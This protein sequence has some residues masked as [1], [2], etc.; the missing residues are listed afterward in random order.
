M[1]QQLLNTTNAGRLAPLRRLGPG[2]PPWPSGQHLGFSGDGRWLSSTEQRGQDRMRWWKL[3]ERT[4]SPAVSLSLKNGAAAVVLAGVDR[5]LSATLGGVLQEWSAVDGALRREHDLGAGVSGL[6]LAADGRTLLITGGNG[7]AWLWDVERWQRVGELEKRTRL[8]YGCALSPD[9]RLAAAGAG[10]QGQSAPGSVLI[11][12]VATGTLTKE[13]PLEAYWV[14]SVAFHPSEPLLVAGTPSHGLST[15][16]LTRWE[17]IRK[18]E[19]IGTN[20]VSFSP[21]GALLAAGGTGFSVLDFHS[22]SILYEHSDDNDMQ[23]SHAVFSPDGRLIA[24]GQGD[25]TVGL[26]GVEE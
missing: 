26:W 25:G 11:W 19:S 2:G 10:H 7:D 9:G 14:W 5:V 21:D 15:L 3:S 4:E 1:S 13:V 20:N 12:D 18:M 8:L 24:W 23:S 17:V 6:T 22:G 16:D